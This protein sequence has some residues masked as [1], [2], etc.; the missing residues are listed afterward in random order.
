M[1]ETKILKDYDSIRNITSLSSIVENK[2][3]GESVFLYNNG[4]VKERGHWYNDHL[5][6]DLASF[7]KNGDVMGMAFY[8]YNRRIDTENNFFLPEKPDKLPSK[9]TRTRFNTLEI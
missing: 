8:Y 5:H 3:H 9:S 7:Y 6:G 2:Y 1:P 4:I